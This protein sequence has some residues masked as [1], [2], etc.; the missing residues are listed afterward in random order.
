ML[1]EFLN[2][3][4]GDM[5]YIASLLLGLAMWRWGSGPERGMAIMFTVVMMGPAMLFRIIANASMLFGNFSAIYVLID[6]IAL[7]GFMAIALNANRNYPLWVAGFQLVAV[8]SHMVRGITDVVSPIA[9]AILAIGPSYCQ[10]AVLLVGLVRHRRR[11]R[12]FGAYRDWRNGHGLPRLAAALS[13][14]E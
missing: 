2:A 11:I 7:A 3:H 10:L 6:V 8:G 5:Q 14:K 4:R 13:A 9:Y 12:R 1:L